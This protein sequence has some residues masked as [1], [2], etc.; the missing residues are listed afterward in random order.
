MTIHTAI[1]AWAFLSYDHFLDK[2]L[3]HTYVG[4]TLVAMAD[5][6]ELLCRNTYCGS[7]KQVS[8]GAITGDYIIV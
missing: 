3:K 4:S 7:S 5:Q 2:Y 6:D 1:F 8:L